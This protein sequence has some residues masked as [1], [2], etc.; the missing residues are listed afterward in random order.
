MYPHAGS[1]ILPC[2]NLAWVRAPCL[3]AWC[4]GGL[5]V[6][7][8]WRLTANPPPGGLHHCCSVIPTTSV[9]MNGGSTTSKLSN[10]IWR[11]CSRQYF[12]RACSPNDRQHPR[13]SQ[14]SNEL[15]VCSQ[16]ARNSSWLAFPQ[17]CADMRTIR[18]MPE[19]DRVDDTGWVN[20]GMPVLVTGVRCMA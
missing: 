6:S 2:R 10:G 7:Y 8:S 13:P 15:G 16:C 20:K 9:G 11:Q 14:E 18:G 12:S 19:W 1:C 3:V 17:R 4:L 5:S